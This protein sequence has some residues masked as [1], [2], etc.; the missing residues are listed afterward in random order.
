MGIMLYRVRAFTLI[1]LALV[2]VIVSLMTGF[3]MQAL[4]GKTAVNCYESTQAQLQNINAALQQFAAQQSRL[5]KP[6]YMNLGSNDSGFGQ[7]ALTGVPDA[8]GKNTPAF[9][10]GVPTGMSET[11]GTLIGALPHATLGL[12]ASYAADCWGNKFTYAVVNSQTSSDSASG[13][14]SGIIGDIALYAGTLGAPVELSQT[15]TY[16][17]ISHGQD[18]YGATPLTANNT[19]ALN[20]NGSTADKIDRENCNNDKV[21]YNTMRSVGDTSNYFDDMLV[22]SSKSQSA[23]NCPAQSVTW[24]PGNACTASTAVINHGTAPIVSNTALNWTGSATASCANGVLTVTAIN[25]DPSAP[26]PAGT[27]ASWGSGCSGTT[28]APIAHAQAPAVTVNNTAANKMGSANVSCNNGILTYPGPNI[29]NDA[30]A[31]S[32]GAIAWGA[33]CT[34]SMPSMTAGQVTAGVANTTSWYTGT[35]DVTCRNTTNGAGASFFDLTNSTCVAAPPA[36]C[37]SQS[38]SW[39]GCTGTAPGLAHNGSTNINDNDV[40]KTGTATVT[41]YNGTSTA[42][43]SCYNDCAAS[44]QNWGSGC[45]SNFPAIG[46]NGGAATQASTAPS[47]T[48][49]VTITCNDGSIAQ[50]GATCTAPC[51]VDGQAQGG[52][53]CCNPDTDGNGMCGFQ[54]DCNFGCYESCAPCMNAPGPFDVVCERNITSTSPCQAFCIYRTEA[55]GGFPATECP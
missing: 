19:T 47:Y 27:L 15:V 9:G 31:C 44:T 54:E 50:S 7:E 42:S 16:L 48:G 13:Y 53:T 21:F 2:L 10:A 41:C 25:C 51:I 26:C 29:C 33:A 35:T 52:G 45:S 23:E 28:S 36:S 46:G 12:A 14:N 4:E 11:G 39:G 38:V 18:K 30:P 5:P 17:V 55:H 8:A 43:G 37:A 22:F 40:N 49:S 20:C 34:A 1:E 32:A 24:G 3:G 6:A